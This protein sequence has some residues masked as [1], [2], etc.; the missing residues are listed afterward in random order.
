MHTHYVL[1][2]RHCHCAALL[3]CY[4][5]PLSW[6]T[7]QPLSCFAIVATFCYHCCA[8]HLIY[9]ASLPTP[10]R[11][12]QCIHMHRRDAHT[13]I[14]NSTHTHKYTLAHTRTHRGTQTCTTTHAVCTLHTYGRSLTSS[15]TVRK[16]NSARSIDHSQSHSHTYQTQRYI[17][18]C[19]CAALPLHCSMP[20]RCAAATAM[21]HCTSLPLT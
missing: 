20:L 19:H 17:R 8:L 13:F 2:L 21:L 12:C 15:H 11:C 6:C 1:S 14:Q 3:H 5:L 10:L 7:E 16:L 18:H 4:M 9:T